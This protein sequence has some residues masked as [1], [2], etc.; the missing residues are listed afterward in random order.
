ME[1]GKNLN[2]FCGPPDG[3]KGHGSKSCRIGKSIERSNM[4]VGV[5]FK[6][7]G[8]GRHPWKGDLEERL[9]LSGLLRWVSG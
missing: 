2:L 5:T 4:G 7:R 6:W 9:W 1:G 3:S 8:H